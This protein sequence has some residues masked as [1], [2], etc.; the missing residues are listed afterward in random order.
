LVP[1]GSVADAANRKTTNFLHV[2]ER[3]KEIQQLYTATGLTMSPVCGLAKLIE[4]AKS[5]ADNWLANQTADNSMLDVFYALHLDRIADA[6]LPLRDV[7][8]RDRYLNTLTSGNIDFF[9]RENSHAKNILWELELWSLL[10]RACPS[11][12]LQDPPDI[13]LPLTGGRLGVSCKKT[14]SENNIEKVLSEA[15]SQVEGEFD[16][17]VV[18]LTH[19][20]VPAAA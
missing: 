5:L 15:V 18:A 10:R 7:P 14:Y 3:A 9:A 17:G 11:T 12:I 13:V 2:K 6:I 1:S 4:N 19:G 8:G 20:R 16:V